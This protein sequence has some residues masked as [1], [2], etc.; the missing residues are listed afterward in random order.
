MILVDYIIS[1]FWLSPLFYLAVLLIG[2][3]L[4]WKTKSELLRKNKDVVRKIDKMIFQIPTVG[5][6]QSINK[7]FETVKGYNLPIPIETWA[8]IEASNTH[9]AE[10]VCDRV[11]VVPADF[12]CEDLYKARALEYARQIKS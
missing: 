12:E 4:N 9:K 3:F 7:I 8:V 6:V 1:I 10:Y 2:K 5:N 11:V